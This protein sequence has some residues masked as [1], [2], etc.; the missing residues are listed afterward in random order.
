MF[1]CFVSIHPQ[2]KMDR[3]RSRIFKS[4]TRRQD[5]REQA[6]RA[7]DEAIQGG[8]DG[9]I[10]WFLGGVIVFGTA[11]IVWPM[12]RGLTLQFKVFVMFAGLIVGIL[13]FFRWRYIALRLISSDCDG[14]SD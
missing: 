2:A 8:I 10:R 4:M 11:Q 1:I 6:D 12:Y 13:A 9:G 5:I 3:R 14:C 7:N